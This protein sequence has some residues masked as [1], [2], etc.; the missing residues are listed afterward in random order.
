MMGELF[1]IFDQASA[2]NKG[3]LIALSLVVPLTVIT[4]LALNAAFRQ[5]GLKN[6]YVRVF[7]SIGVGSFLTPFIYMLCFKVVPIPAYIEITKELTGGDFDWKEKLLPIAYGL[8]AFLSFM[9]FLIVARKG[10]A[11]YLREERKEP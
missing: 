6:P 4:L 2:T 3:A 8:L 7:L 10:L 5:M 1:T 9:V 11:R